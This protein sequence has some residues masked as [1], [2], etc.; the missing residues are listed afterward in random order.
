MAD[1]VEVIL[2]LRNVSQFVSGARSASGAIEQVGSDAEK[3]GKKAH[4]GW[5]GLAKWAGGAAAMYAASRYVKSA[6]GATEDLAKSTLTLQRTTGMDTQTASEWA[7]LTKERGISTKQFQ[8]S[9]VKLSR[10]MET[11]R[12]GTAK[13]LSTVRGLREQIDAVAAAGGKKAPA[14]I[15]K[16]SKAIA[17]AQ[18]AGEKSRQTL[19]L[20]GIS[21]AN[22]GKGNTQLVL[23]KVADALEKIHNPARRAA[24]MQQVFG[25]SG[26]ALLP[27]LLKGR[28]GVQ[29]LLDQQKKYGNYLS[30]KNIGD[31]KK[32]I[33][34]Q[35]EMETAM[36]GVKVQLGVALLPVMVQ[37]GHIIVSITR[38]MQPLTKNALLFKIA[39]G[40]LATAFIAYKVATIAATIAQSG[41]TVAMLPTVGIVLAIVAAIAALVF[42]GYELY[43]HWGAIQKLAGTVWA[44]VL[45]SMQNVWNWVKANWPL[46]VGILTGPFGFAVAM[47]IKHFHTIVG[48]IKGAINYV[49]R[50]WNALQFKLPAINTHIPGVGKIGGQSIGVP[51]IPELAAGG[52]IRRPGTV[53]V[54]ERGPELLAL[55]GGAAVS[56]LTGGM[57][58]LEITVPVMI[59]GRELGRSVA[60]VA[61]DRLAR[62]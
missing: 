1:V 48:A 22:V 18:T 25:R 32:L 10:T 28:K 52:V 15:D 39:I 54:G 35:R 13:Q 37:L 4:A 16:L 59:D 61:A 21:A 29:E 12:T 51:Q 17:R 3:S 2:A 6:V 36:R 44:S 41:L 47:I 11:S 23:G 43:K 14:Q 38:A 40:A 56:P 26:Q 46:L 8:T 42:I 45:S 9:L 24:L 19:A 31:T 49:I 55:P 62:R 5:K 58:P 27:I 30:G 53:L 57:R 33:E 34:Q 50:G 7:A 20:L 60:R